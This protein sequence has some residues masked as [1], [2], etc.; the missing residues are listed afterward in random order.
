MSESCPIF[1]AVKPGESTKTFCNKARHVE[2]ERTGGVNLIG[3]S[4]LDVH[5]DL[6]CAILAKFSPLLF[7]GE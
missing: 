1:A 7:L 5:C 6:S 3:W 2:G 4:T